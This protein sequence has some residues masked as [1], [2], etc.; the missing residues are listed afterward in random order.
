[1]TDDKDKALAY[2]RAA[3]EKTA[4][5]FVPARVRLPK[6]V[7]GDFPFTSTRA[8]AGEHDCESNQWGAVSVL[9]TDGTMLGVRPAEFDVV[10]W[11][12]NREG[13]APHERD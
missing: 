3:T 7:T 5:P 9:A 2:Y 10:G 1:M 8:E 11:R 13:N 12:P 6:A 4:P